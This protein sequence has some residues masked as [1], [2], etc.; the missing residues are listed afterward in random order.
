VSSGQEGATAIQV[1][2]IGLAGAIIGALIGGIGSFLGVFV[3][4]RQQRD[5]EAIDARRNAYA[6]LV[7]K[8]YE[9][10]ELLIDL[11]VEAAQKDQEAYNRDRERLASAGPALTSAR[12][13]VELIGSEGL[14]DESE[15]ITEG[16]FSH[17]YIPRSVDE[18]VQIDPA[19]D[20]AIESGTK[21]ISDF[22]TAARTD[23][24]RDQ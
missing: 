4:Y 10:R 12:V 24:V 18:F 17:P 5:A 9:Y 7:T 8:A 21:A 15:A 6:T 20:Q 3:T 11:G 19:V 16:F 2:R 14:I 1:G 13:A 23:I 22:V